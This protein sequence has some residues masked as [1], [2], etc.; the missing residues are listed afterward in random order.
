MKFFP[1]NK[2][3]ASAQKLRG[4]YYTPAVLADYLVAW[5]IRDGSE[6]ILEPSCG[7]GN[8]IEATLKRLAD[9][10]NRSRTVSSSI[11]AIEIDRSEIAIAKQRTSKYRDVTEYISWYCS[12]F[13]RIYGRL[14]NEERFD[15]VIG[16]PPFIRFQYFDDESREI[17]FKH[18]R[19]ADYHPTKL[20]NAWAAF[21]Q[22]SVELLRPGGRL[23][24]VLP[25]ELLQV[26]YA[27][28]LREKL[29]CIFEHIVLIGF[30]Q[31]VFPQIQQE[32]VL[33]L[34][35][36]KR[37]RMGEPSNI[38]TLQYKD[39]YELLQVKN[40]DQAVAHLPSKHNRKG[41]KWTALF[42][43]AKAFKALDEAERSGIEMRLGD[44]A[45]VD[46][47]VVT[48]RNSFFVIQARKAE[49]LRVNGYVV[50]VVGRTSA[51]KSIS[52]T[53]KD[54][55]EYSEKHASRLINLSGIDRETFSKELLEYIALGE[56]RT[57]N[58]G[59]KCRIRPRWYDVP[60]VYIPD[61]FLFR[62]IHNAPMLVCNRALASST[63]TIHRV[64]VNPGVD[65]DLLCAASI[66]SMTFAWA[67]VCGRSYG[68]GVLE[69]EPGEAEQLPIPYE[70]AAELDIEKIDT[71]LR[72]GKLKSALDY[73]DK[74]LLE[75]GLGFGK[76]T[77]ARIRSA[78]AELRDRRMN[79]RRPRARRAM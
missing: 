42:L 23:A 77:V 56:E 61:A 66:N 13:F 67:E 44:L 2:V 9:I 55:E 19:A 48:G 63:D 25:A 40:L 33:L 64:R 35:E 14:A 20:A 45:Q 59:Y 22:L 47:G 76:G 32:V 1:T 39:G 24:F 17:A 68:G 73:T 26:H 36:G 62:Q 3:P 31:L 50:P 69:L 46:V 58:Q 10:T 79:R 71:L 65:V 34:A 38:H 49:Q 12:D 53:A 43:S 18:L 54:F 11:S 5:A 41:L 21:V 60:S 4:G 7:D 30:D 6:R 72:V 37:A 78:W 16:N 57:I 27:G 29:A 28:E 51:L 8:F 70:R 15:V 75:E 52:F 74:V